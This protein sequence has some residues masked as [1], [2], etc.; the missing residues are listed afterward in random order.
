MLIGHDGG[1]IL[2]E[3][4]VSQLFEDLQL[5]TYGYADDVRRIAPE[6]LAGGPFTASSDIYA[7]AC[8]A[9]GM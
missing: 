3:A 1:P 9:A 8:L 6:V 7:F 4:G 5:G 2:S